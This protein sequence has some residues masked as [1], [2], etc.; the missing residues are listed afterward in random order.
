MTA[1]GLAVRSL[2]SPPPSLPK[3]QN[4][5]SIADR[6]FLRG[7]SP[8]SSRIFCLCR[9]SRSPEAIFSPRSLH[10]KIPFPAAQFSSGKTIDSHPGTGPHGRANCGF[11][12]CRVYCGLSPSASNCRFH[13]AGASRS[14]S[15]PMPRGRRPSTAALTSSGARKASEMVI[16]TCRTLHFSRVAICSSSVTWPETIWSSHRRLRAIAATRAGAAVI[17]D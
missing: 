13:S 8:L 17:L 10:P 12:R 15:T 5:S 9:R 1:W 7:Y 16:L 2:P 6:P 3:P 11:S 14:R 4:L